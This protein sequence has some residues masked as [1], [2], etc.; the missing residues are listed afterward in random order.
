MTHHWSPAM[1]RYQ[2]RFWPLMAAYT[3]LILGAAWLIKHGPPLGAWRYLVAVAPS[4]PLIGV[5]AAFGFYLGDMEEFRRWIV[6]QSMLWAIGLVLTFC[7]VWG[8]LEML[9]GA[10]HLELWWV[11]PIYSV[12]Q[13]AAQTLVSRRYA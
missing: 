9:A 8:F 10:P 7:T 4:V 11:F 13:G 5:F 1:K 12:T 2:G 6:V 3:V